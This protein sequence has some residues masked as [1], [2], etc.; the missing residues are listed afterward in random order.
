MGRTV[1]VAV[2]TLNQWAM[3]FDGNTRRILQS[4]QE[5]KDA[6][7]TYRSGPELE[8]CGYSCED[9]FY[10]SDTLLHSWEVLANLLRSS[11]CEDMLID[12]GMPVMHKNVTYNC[13]VAFLN[14]RI[15]LIR[16][17]MRLCEDGNYRES[18]WFSPWTKERT[19][20][21]YF[22]PRMISQITSQNV[23]PFGDAVIATRDTCIGFEIC[24]E[25]WHPASNHIPM[26]LD[27]VEIIANGSG[28]YF[29]LRKAY[30]TVD[31]VKS[32][33][34]KAGGCYMFSNLRGCDG[35]RLYFN[36]GS[37][38][39]LNGN[40]LNRGRQFALED[41]EVTIATFDLE[42]IRNYRNGIRSR[43]HA[44]AATPSYPRVKVDFALTPENLISN[45]PDR[46]LDGPQ[47]IYEDDDGHSRLVYH[48]PEEEIAMA[49]ACWLWDYLR[50]CM[51]CLDT[52]V[53][54]DIRKIVGDCEYTP[55][56]P[57]QLCNTI[58]FTCY[59]GTENSSAETKARA[60]ELASQ[61]GSYHHSIVIDTA[62]SA[63]LGIFQQVTKLT[64]RFR[65]QGGS[66]RENLALQNVQARLRMV[67][68]YLFAQLMLW[69]KG[70]P[71]GLLVLGSGNVDEALRG[72][73]TKYDC[74]SADINPIGGIAKNDLKKFL[75][76]FR[77][78]H[79]ISSLDGILDAPPTAELEPLQAGQLAQLDEVDMGMTYN[80]LSI[81]GRLR[82][83]NCAGPF[84]MFCRLV[85]MWDHC[86]P[87]EVADKVKHFYR[88]YAI[89]RHKMTIL[90]PSCHAETYSP[91]DNRF[92][93]RPFLYN[94]TWKWQFA[95]I[96]E[97]VK[98][99]SSEEKSSRPHKDAPKV[100]AK[101]RYM[102]FSSVIS[103]E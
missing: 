100:P 12:V 49:P 34:F 103:S 36:G 64:P 95:A 15:L 81:F 10:E 88:C 23:V 75:L 39:T 98:R 43:S 84:T 2:C 52:Q 73:L 94:H 59:M 80:E 74:S 28:S 51:S 7:A 37:S 101:P 85:H 79:G 56:D 13:R 50:K 65:I 38:I 83:Q 89:H 31:L 62:I 77:R 54:A 76:Y 8:I 53:L 18:R 4:I 24:E 82:K 27:G 72:Y 21:D 90:T 19:V 40:I 1:T 87:K 44:A 93:H 42:D 66:P 70:R 60:A 25:L 86:T 22:L 26:S 92:D 61:I 78:K 102:P 55:V 48:I 57:K 91:D 69:V 11:V 33:T 67:I 30:V 29:E 45:P 68:A 47:D 41:V 63:I 6:G 71:G 46:P 17:K 97:Q 5:A 3:D 58:L 9:H 35:G 16:P 14:R 32:A 96:D 99:L 20:E